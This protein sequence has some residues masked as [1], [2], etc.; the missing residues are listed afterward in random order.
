MTSLDCQAGIVETQQVIHVF[1]QRIRIQ[2]RKKALR[3]VRRIDTL[4]DGQQR[5]HGSG[6]E[7]VDVLLVASELWHSPC[8]LVKIVSGQSVSWYSAFSAEKTP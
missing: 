2:G 5:R 1:D 3:N 4:E 7:P 8:L 6:F